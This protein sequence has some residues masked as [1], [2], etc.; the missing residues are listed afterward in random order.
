MKHE[1]F[2]VGQVIFVLLQE[3]MKVVAL[4]VVEEINRRTIEGET[5]SYI[6]QNRPSDKNYIPLE[7]VKGEVFSDLAEIKELLVGNATLH[8]ERLID[9]VRAKSEIFAIDSFAND[10]DVPQNSGEFV[11]LEDGTRAR[12]RV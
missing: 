2:E 5:T 7:S 11:I 12:V 3:K 9:A 4:R 6:V 10:A 8:I 1:K